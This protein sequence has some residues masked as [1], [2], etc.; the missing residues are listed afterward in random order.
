MFGY[1]SKERVT[2]ERALRAERLDLP[3]ET[4]QWISEIDFHPEDREYFMVLAE[5]AQHGNL[6]QDENEEMADFV[7]VGGVLEQF[8][9]AAREALHG[10]DEF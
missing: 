3:R 2:P 1:E 8:R 5:K 7:I 6:T 10:P 9:N 4:M